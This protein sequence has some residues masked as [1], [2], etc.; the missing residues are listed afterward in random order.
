MPI[1]ARHF[2]SFDFVVYDL[3]AT[4]D[5]IRD[6]FAAEAISAHAYASISS[7]L[8]E[9]RAGYPYEDTDVLI[10][11]NNSIVALTNFFLEWGR[12]AANHGLSVEN[13]VD[14]T[15]EDEIEQ[16]I[17]YITI[18]IAAQGAFFTE[19]EALDIMN[20]DIGDYDGSLT[21]DLEGNTLE[22]VD[23]DYTLG[24]EDSYSM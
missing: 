20:D 15:A 13:P 4:Q 19:M 21:F 10:A 16:H 14:L 6:L 8:V 23:S 18:D 24:S 3:H 7:V 22:T 5:Y 17:E 2:L 1:S 9:L 12:V 11:P